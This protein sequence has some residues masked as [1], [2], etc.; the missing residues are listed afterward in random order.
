[1]FVPVP[2]SVIIAMARSHFATAVEFLFSLEFGSNNNH[3]M[4][5]CAQTNISVLAPALN[6]V[7]ITT[8]FPWESARNEPSV[9]LLLALL[10]SW[11]FLLGGVA[12]LLLLRCLCLLVHTKTPKAVEEDCVSTMDMPSMDA[13]V[14]NDEDD[15][16]EDYYDDHSSIK[17]EMP[18]M[19]EMPGTDDVAE[20]E[21]QDL[22]P[23]AAKE[24]FE[25]TKSKKGQ[26]VEVR[27]S[28][29]AARKPDRLTM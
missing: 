7:T 14:D 26:W 28:T 21:E 22:P 11:Q 1:M 4:N 10:P 5:D 23:H 13:S 29:R 27:R 17:E 9:A 25:W 16:D 19:E 6:N 24:G 15:E 3:K 18:S 8:S 20:E 12:A 2:S